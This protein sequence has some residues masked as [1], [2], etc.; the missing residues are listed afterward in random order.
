L[1]A[2]RRHELEQ[3]LT[4]RESSLD[5]IEGLK[6][7]GHR[8]SDLGFILYAMKDLGLRS[9][10][11]WSFGDLKQLHDYV[12]RMFF[13]RRLTVHAQDFQYSGAIGLDTT[14]GYNDRLPVTPDSPKL[15]FRLESLDDRKVLV[16]E[17]GTWTDWSRDNHLTRDGLTI[18]LGAM[19]GRLH[20]STTELTMHYHDPNADRNRRDCWICNSN[21]CT[22]FIHLPVVDVETAYQN[23]GP[24][25]VWHLLDGFWGDDAARRPMKK[26]LSQ[27]S[28]RIRTFVH[29]DQVVK[30]FTSGE[31][32]F[33][34]LEEVL[35]D[36]NG[37]IS[38]IK[39]VQEQWEPFGNSLWPAEIPASK[40]FEI[41]PKREYRDSTFGMISYL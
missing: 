19:E 25:V 41:L 3:E 6:D 33:G 20:S 27:R 21:R 34:V 10:R 13:H 5:R 12:G 7:I 29:K 32:Y 22:R 8:Y 23:F 11:G 31:P 37:N 35:T 15:E 38:G 17:I 14:G 26:P 4:S 28:L 2:K 24:P 39:I 1:T 40:I 9:H 36:K 16:C 18:S 30:V